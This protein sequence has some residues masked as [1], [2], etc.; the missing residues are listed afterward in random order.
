[1]YIYISHYLRIYDKSLDPEGKDVLLVM[2][3]WIIF[4][5]LSSI[6]SVK[7]ADLIGYWALNYIAFFWFC[8]NHCAVIFIK[9]YYLFLLFYGI[10][11]GIACGLGY[12]PAIYTAWTYFPE[13]K[14]MATGLILLSTGISFFFL[15]PLITLL[16]N[17]DNLKDEHE[18]VEK[19][20]P[21][22]FSC[23][24]AAFL[25]ITLV[26]CSLLPSPW[27]CYG[28]D[29]SVTSSSSPYIGRSLKLAML[30]EKARNLGI[31]IDSNKYGRQQLG[32]EVGTQDGQALF[33]VGQLR[34]ENV[35]EL[36]VNME[37][38]DAQNQTF[39]DDGCNK[40][41]HLVIPGDLEQEIKRINQI[42]KER[43][44]PSMRAA[45]T[46]PSF[47]MIVGMV[48]CSS[49][50]YY[51]I[52]SSWKLHFKTITGL[53]DQQLSYILSLGSI[54]NAVGKGLCGIL[55]LK[56]DFK[57]VYIVCN[58]LI[59]IYA[60]SYWYLMNKFKSFYLAA[61][62]LVLAFFGL[63]MSLTMFPTICIK[64][65]GVKVGSRVYPFIYFCFALSNLVAY[66]FY[67]H[68]H[69][70]QATFTML[71]I[72]AMLG[73]ILGVFFNQSPNWRTKEESSS[74]SG[75]ELNK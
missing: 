24:T 72:I 55:L 2:P 26:S 46:S 5:S 8:V 36:T 56:I 35:N 53:S 16:V 9:N 74:H 66:I 70:T 47:S 39:P 75:I 1:M 61:S 60:F 27:Y 10:F 34:Q 15:S 11:N 44:C 4:L 59:V 63:G 7:I 21:L 19:R 17:P 20:V 38:V 54:G 30:L 18:D 58:S 6:I 48:L 23:L 49:V 31:D 45:I 57:K 62:Y 3:L 68:I 28:S 50:Y 40:S 67:K 37:H 41:E 29:N 13:K 14:S 25:V 43:S 22:M 12:L 69:S 73:V 42:I 52:L 51:L 33:L 64:V 32:E 65:F 71:G